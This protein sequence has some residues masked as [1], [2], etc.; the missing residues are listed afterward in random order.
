MSGPILNQS[1]PASPSGRPHLIL[2]PDARGVD[3][4]ISPVSLYDSVL[5]ARQ[6]D[7]LLAA[8]LQVLV[9]RSQ[10]AASPPGALLQNAR[11]AC[12]SHK[13]IRGSDPTGAKTNSTHVKLGVF[14]FKG[15]VLLLQKNTREKGMKDS[16]WGGPAWCDCVWF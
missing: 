10:V 1:L 16:S 3:H 9:Q 5:L 6:V 11:R 2:H 13:H 14:L 8:A 4:A 15:V 7:Q 12:T